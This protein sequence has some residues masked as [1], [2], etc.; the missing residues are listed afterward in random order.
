MLC[1]F[2]LDQDQAGVVVDV[3]GQVGGG[4]AAPAFAVAFTK[5]FCRFEVVAVFFIFQMQ[6]VDRLHVRG[7]LFTE[8]A[9]QQ[10][11]AFRSRAE[12]EVKVG[13]LN[14]GTVEVVLALMRLDV[15]LGE[16]GRQGITRAGADAGPE[17]LRPHGVWQ[18]PRA[19]EAVLG[20]VL[21][22]DAIAWGV[23][24][25]DLMESHLIVEGIF[26]R[27]FWRCGLSVRV[28]KRD[29]RCLEKIMVSH[30]RLELGEGE[31]LRTSTSF[32]MCKNTSISGVVDS[33]KVVNG[34][35]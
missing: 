27:I 15:V 26:L 32:L 3:E 9:G 33:L 17:R 35:L 21:V 11:P 23:S 4:L 7:H 1:Q 34:H 19:S 13:A 2:V 24:P 16:I 25:G 28:I 8:K 6:L 20:A 22:A 18:N 31:L 14:P 29:H 5:Q 30:T 12:G 10:L